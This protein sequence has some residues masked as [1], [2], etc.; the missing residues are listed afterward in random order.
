MEQKYQI[1]EK[2]YHFVTSYRAFSNSYLLFLADYFVVRNE[3]G[4]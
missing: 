4:V 2:I 1:R 3:Y